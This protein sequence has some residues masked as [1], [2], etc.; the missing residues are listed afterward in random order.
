V[1]GTFFSPALIG[2]EHE[3]GICI[4]AEV[5]ACRLQGTGEFFSIIDPSIQRQA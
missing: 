3:F 1:F 2:A 5:E 4:V